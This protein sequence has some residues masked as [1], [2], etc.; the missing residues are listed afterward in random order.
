MWRACL[1]ALT[2]SQKSNSRNLNYIM[3]NSYARVSN[4]PNNKYR[5]VT[6]FHIKHKIAYSFSRVFLSLFH[7]TTSSLE[8]SV[9]PKG[10]TNLRMSS[11]LI[12][13][14]DFEYLNYEAL[15]SIKNMRSL[16][17]KF[18]QSTQIIYEY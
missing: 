8:E 3:E 5:K 15:Y 13:A 18:G 2:W 12:C 10:D 1:D 6:T 9:S 14:Q 11:P 7:E 16:I 17:Y 4:K